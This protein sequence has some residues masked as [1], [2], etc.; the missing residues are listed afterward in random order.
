MNKVKML[1]E[2]DIDWISLQN[3]SWHNHYLKN[4]LK[5][6]TDEIILLIKKNIYNL[7][8]SVYMVNKSEF[9]KKCT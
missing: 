4:Y 9:T 5:S 1:F 2:G 6:F 3:M 7:L 8:H